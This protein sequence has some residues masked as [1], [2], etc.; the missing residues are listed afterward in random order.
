MAELEDS[1]S[2]NSPGQW[3]A[4]TH[5]SVVLTAGH[6]SAPGARDALE[7]LCRAYWYPLYAFA[8]RHGN[9]PEDAQDLT[10]E[11]FAR[12]LEKEYVG[13]ADPA[14]GRFRSYLLACLKNFLAEQHRHAGRLKRGG[15]KT[16]VS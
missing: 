12:F 8:R 13:L 3:F 7:K 15:G 5:W 14:R 10:Q 4:T 11:F 16:I 6:D 2:L 1:R 9:N